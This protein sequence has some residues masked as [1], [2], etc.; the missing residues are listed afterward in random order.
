MNSA[1]T[2]HSETI[3][4]NPLNLEMIKQPEIYSKQECA[5]FCRKKDSFWELSNMAGGMPLYF[6][7][8]KWNSSEQLYQASKYYPDAVCIP[9]S[10]KTKNNI[11]ANV[12]ERIKAQANARGAKMTQKCA[13]KAGLVRHD[14]D[15]PNHEVRILSMLWVLE[16]KLYHNRIS[17]NNTPSFGEILKAT[18]TRPIVEVSRKDFFWGCKDTGNGTLEGQNVLGKLLEIVRDRYIEIRSQ[19]FLYPD[20]FLLES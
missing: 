16:L 3:Q 7:N 9:D 17:L 15:D 8:T 12:V 18:G 1:S 14:W 5:W 2:I 13:V 20:G 11:I 19:N 10:S 6:D 4:N